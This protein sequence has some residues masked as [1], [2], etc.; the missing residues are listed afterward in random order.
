MREH[1]LTALTP[2][3]Y[4]TL[5]RCSCGTQFWAGASGL[6]C[7]SRKGVWIPTCPM[8]FYEHHLRK[9]GFQSFFAEGP[10]EFTVDLETKR[11]ILQFLG[12]ANGE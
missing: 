3:D 8:F 1:T 4:K 6:N 11:R 12:I 5:F 9:A 10:S 7:M 2:K